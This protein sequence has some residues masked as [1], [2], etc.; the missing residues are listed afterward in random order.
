MAEAIP[1]LKDSLEIKKVKLGPDHP[2]T[3]MTMNNL[4]GCYMQSGNL[5]QAL[6]L[7]K[8][9]LELLKAKVGADHPNTIRTM[10]N[11]ASIYMRKRQFD[12]A[13]PLFEQA[14]K[15]LRDKAGPEHPTTVA[16][17]NN[18]LKAYEEWGKP[19][20]ALTIRQQNFERMKEKLG[21]DHRDT[22]Q[23]ANELARQ[24]WLAKQ[25]DKSIPL[26]EEV[27]RAF[28]AKFGRDDANTLLVLANLG[29]NYKDAGQ[30]D[31][32]LPLL[33]E[34]YRASAKLP[35]LRVVEPQLLDGYLKAGKTKQAEGLVKNVLESL[36]KQFPK[37]SPQLAGSLAQLALSMTQAKAFDMAEPVLRE[38]LAIREKAQPDVWTTYNT[39]STL[40]GALLGQ[41]K[42]ADA[43]PLLLKGYEG[44]KQ[45]EKTIPKS[46]GGELRIPEALDRL[47][48]LYTATNKPDEVKKWQ[49]E[50]AK[51]VEPVEKGPMPREVK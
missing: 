46:G 12:Q 26:F 41:K 29:V 15:V 6:P 35:M 43:E 21:A 3:L 36:R 19:S 51:F 39:Q 49:A 16:I 18:L 27:A 7:M 50:R 47:V 8:E 37:E 40:G 13:V 23:A 44:M 25:L 42:Y 5:D 10:N 45:R 30:L 38:C 20:P 34:A 4:A 31:K 33:E 14:V 17:Q 48:E 1:L 2:D 24:Y 11:L 28:E 32:S 9:T 22:L